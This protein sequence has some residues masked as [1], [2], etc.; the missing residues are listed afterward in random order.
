[1][2]PKSGQIK[3]SLK[4][5]INLTDLN[6]VQVKKSGCNLLDPS[7]DQLSPTVSEK[8]ECRSEHGFQASRTVSKTTIESSKPNTVSKMT[9]ESQKPDTFSETTI[10]SEKQE[11]SSKT[12]VEC[13]KLDTFSKRTI[14]SPKPETKTEV[15]RM[16]FTE[17]PITATK[18]KQESEAT[19]NSIDFD[20]SGNM[21]TFSSPSSP[22]DTF[23]QI[24]PVTDDSKGTGKEYVC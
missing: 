3:E 15:L 17:S 11:T 21:M 9:M 7:I 4:I 23:S 5:V 8:T 16:V 6:P 19:E 13:Q 24:V 10:L 20:Y 2:A 18:T 22:L 1:M 12:I 14:E